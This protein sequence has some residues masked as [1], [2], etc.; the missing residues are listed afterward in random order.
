MRLRILVPGRRRRRSL[1]ALGAAGLLAVAGCGGGHHARPKPPAP[2]PRPEPPLVL[3]VT[4]ANPFLLAPT[5]TPAPFTAW[6]D[7][8]AALKPRYLRVLVV[9]SQVQPRPDAP[10]DWTAPA[11][12]C[13]RGAP[14]CAPFSGIRDELRAARAAGMQVLVTFLGTPAWAARPP[15]GCER[16]GTGPG[17][18]MP[19]DLGAY[20]VLVRSLLEE[21]RS[22][23]VDVAWWSPWNEPNHPAFLNP[24]RASCAAGAPTEAAAGYAELARALKVE[25]DAWPGEQH[26]VLGDAAGYD[27]GSLHRTGAAELARAL[28]DDVACAG[29]V[30]AQH[31]YIKPR[32]DLAGDDQPPGAGPLLRSVE[33][34]LASHGCPGP[35]PRI[36]ITE[37]GARPRTGPEGCEAM[38]DA[39]RIWSQDPRV[40]AAFQYTFRADTAFDVG[41]ADAG[42]TE[43]RPAY[44]AW[45]A[46]AEGHAGEG[47]AA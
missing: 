41:L 13:L 11:D 37:T 30:W 10:P 29:A 43:V 12:G 24:Q 17:S 44:G 40:D 32:G 6:R 23:R 21:A 39:L 3:G 14:P 45:L 1:G 25:L 28:P 36:W 38:A 31:A 27:A 22:D 8:L 7:R 47:C 18:R 5:A 16:A 9:W 26:V 46:A 15:S 4:E 42:L 34:A 19:A 20:R 33:A 35:A 2:E